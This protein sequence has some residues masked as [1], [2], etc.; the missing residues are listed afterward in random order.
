MS[1]GNSFSWL[2]FLLGLAIGLWISVVV[3][4]LVGT[5][6]D[7]CCHG[8]GGTT[9]ITYPAPDTAWVPSGDGDYY[10]TND[11]EG[12]AIVVD[13]GKAI[14]ADEGRAIVIDEGGA[15]IIDEGGAIVA[16]DG[17]VVPA[18]GDDTD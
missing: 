17:G 1:N 2:A 18:P 5:D 8:S 15:I 13:E 4:F 16:D 3:L 12:R 11:D 6:N 9:I 14:V 10:C 7:Q